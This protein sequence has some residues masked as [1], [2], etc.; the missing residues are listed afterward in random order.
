M[1]KVAVVSRK[2]AESALRGAKIYIPGIMGLSSE[3]NNYKP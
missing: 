1:F 3:S 2:C